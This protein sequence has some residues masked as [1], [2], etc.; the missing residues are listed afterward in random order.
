[1]I[2]ISKSTRPNTWIVVSVDEN[3]QL[4]YAPQVNP[5][6][7]TVGLSQASLEIVIT[8]P[9]DQD[10]DVKSVQI[11]IK[12]AGDEK[13]PPYPDSSA[14]TT[15][16]ANVKAAVSDTN[17]TGELLDGSITHG[18][19]RYKL[20][21]LVGLTSKIPAGGSLVVQIYDFPA[22]IVAG[23]STVN[24]KEVTGKGVA[25]PSFTV[26]TFPW[27]FAFSDLVASVHDG[28]GWK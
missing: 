4:S 25:L 26:T 19:A 20:K 7:L 11:T 22:N 12:V 21:P 8:N 5:S 14:L 28:S 1:M 27:G 24:I 10:I 13:Y 9:T 16:T 17:W 2:M 23:T 3:T 18:D 15:T 6:P